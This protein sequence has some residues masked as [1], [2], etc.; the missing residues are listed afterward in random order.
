MGWPVLNGNRYQSGNPLHSIKA[1]DIRFLLNVLQYI[2]GE[3]CY[4]HK[5]PT[6]MGWRIIVPSIPPIDTDTLK[7]D[8]PFDIEELSATEI[9]LTTGYVEIHSD[10][11]TAFITPNPLTATLVPI[12]GTNYVYAEVDP[13][14]E[15]ASIKIA[16]SL[17]ESTATLWCKLIYKIDAG[18]S[19]PVPLVRYCYGNLEFVGWRAG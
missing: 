6:G 2:Q 3:G 15:T 7:P 11:G 10:A 18:A 9:T 13:V 17:P 1:E 4:I 8:T 16:T 19:P 12:A 5:E 14:A